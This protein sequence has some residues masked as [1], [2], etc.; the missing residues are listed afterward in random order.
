[1]KILST[2]VL[3][4]SAWI[5]SIV[6]LNAQASSLIFFTE[7]NE[8]F[9]LYVNGSKI[10]ADPAS[11]VTANDVRVDFAQ[12]KIEFNI[13]GAPVVKSS[14][15]IDPN[16]EMTSM[17]KQNKKGKY[18][19][20]PVSSVTRK[21]KSPETVNLI[22]EIPSSTGQVTNQNSAYKET[23][24][25]SELN[26]NDL[27]I[28]IDGKGVSIN[29]NV[30]DIDLLEKKDSPRSGAEPQRS[31][32]Q[33][34]TARSEGK[35]IILGD[36]RT[37]DWKYTKLRSLT[38]V[39]IEMLE[40]VGAKVTISYDGQTAKETEVPF[41][42]RE[43]D[44]KRSK[45]Y[46]KLAVI[47]TNGTSWSIK[48]Q[49]SNNNRILIDNL[50]GGSVPS[51]TPG[52]SS[53]SSACYKMTT[54][55][56]DQAKKAIASKSFAD[57][58]MIIFNQIIKTNCVA[59][60]QVRQFMDLFT[61]EEEKVEVAKKAYPKTVDQNNY[62]QVNESLTYEDAIEDLNAFLEQQ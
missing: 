32:G 1:M 14:M 16:Q 25:T 55:A 40:P 34:I 56:F 21:N 59:V 42:Y 15:L 8:L 19:L 41:M 51:S 61:Y 49:H 38:G 50:T 53:Q 4:F 18:V 43:P 10:N 30:D 9:S 37:L 33:P 36:G 47:E 6:G 5:L 45:D 12:I 54:S 28:S 20:R 2:T 7:N 3:A 26:S 23:P 11:T 58:K 27:S 22:R 52:S 57:E 29:V 39:E 44:W 35:K 17:I 62:F 48:L 60:S 31:T 46:F 13:P 24:A